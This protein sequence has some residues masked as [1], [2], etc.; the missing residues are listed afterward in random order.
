MLDTNVLVAALRSRKE[1]S[2]RLLSLVGRARFDLYLSV[3]LLLEYE[4]VLGRLGMVD[5]TRNQVDDVLD[6]LCGVARHQD[7]FY[8]WRPC[9]KDPKDDLVLEL[10]VAGRCRY[11]VTFNTRDFIGAVRFGVEVCSPGEFL[12]EIGDIP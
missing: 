11:L 8:L 7:V 5:L 2:F 10:A 12:A 6:Y 4:S 3:P 1:A 9:L